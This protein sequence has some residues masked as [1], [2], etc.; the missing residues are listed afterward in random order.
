MSDQPPAP[1]RD[2][3]LNALPGVRH[4]F[5]TRRSGVSAGIYESLNCG[6]GSN[7]DPE[8]V[9]EN[10]RRALA[11]LDLPEGALA[12][13]HQVHSPDAVVATAPFPREERPRADAVVTRTP[14]L[15]V[16]VLTADC[17]PVLLAD[18]H[19]GVVGAAHA[20]WRGALGGVL[21]A[22]LARMEGEGADRRCI[23]AAVGPCIGARSYAVSLD[24]IEPF[25]D[26]DPAN[27]R[28]F[29][30]LPA[31]DGYLFDLA[32]YTVAVLEAA[33]VG[34]VAALGRDTY[35]DAAHFFS[36]R[37]ARHRGEPDYGRLLAAIALAG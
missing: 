6:P 9:A 36:H 27:A 5:F 3:G 4:G 21:D 33:G 29:R 37:R 17:A 22:C 30:A 20:G 12:T 19:A 23:T 16:G 34:T 13:L 1:L 32:G 11:A 25:T 35:A 24:F 2:P 18:A 26:A 28:F 8:T 10:R 7:D 31:G 15:A 14:G